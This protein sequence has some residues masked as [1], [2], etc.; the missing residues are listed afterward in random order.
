LTSTTQTIVQ[1]FEEQAA[2]MR[3][4]FAQRA[5]AAL[6]EA[7]REL[8]ADLERTLVASALH[9]GDEAPDFELP[10]AITGGLVRLSEAAARGPI[11]VSFYR[12]QWCPYCNLEVRNL[13]SIH[14]SVRDLGGEIYLVG[15]ETVD[16]AAKLQEKTGTSIPIL[17]DID[18]A[19]AARY[20][21][22]FELP[23]TIQQ[24]YAAMG[25]DLPKANSLTG[26]KLPIPA[27]LVV[28]KDQRIAACYVN[29]DYTHRM[30]ASAILEA[31]ANAARA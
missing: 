22:M 25:I 12:G 27:T 18:G 7:S 16:N 4:G 3:E 17:T 13:Q 15:P 6:Q 2:A 5:P 10:E 14:G 21:L 23:P 29:A 30:E 24:S 28:G 9:E 11:V 26:W 20:Q 8:I 1:R 19:V 31:A